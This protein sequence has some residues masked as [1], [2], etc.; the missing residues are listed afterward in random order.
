MISITFEIRIKL[1]S[2]RLAKL[3][4]VDTAFFN[5]FSSIVEKGV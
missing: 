4:H 5:L 1:L 3:L 2:V